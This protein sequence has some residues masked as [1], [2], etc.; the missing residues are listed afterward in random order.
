MTK[1]KKGLVILVAG[2]LALGLSASAFG[3]GLGDN[4][5]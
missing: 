2:L 4:K 3:F 1:G 5:F